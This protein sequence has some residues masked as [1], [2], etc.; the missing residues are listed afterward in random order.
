MNKKNIEKCFVI[1]SDTWPNAKCELI[2][3]NDFQLL[4]A[5]VL[6]A[7]TTDKSVNKALGPI[8]EKNQQFNAQDLLKIGE[9]QFLSLIKSIGLAPTKAKNAVKIASIL[10]EKFDS[11]VP[12][13]RVDLEALPGVGRKTTNVILNILN[14]EPIIAVDTHVERVSKRLNLASIQSNR[15]EVE[16]ELYSKIPEKF[17]DK[18]HHLLI[19][20]GRYL[21]TARN[22]KCGSC[23]LEKIC[24]K[25]GV[26]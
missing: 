20:Q 17:H 7:Q 15:V 25:I 13:N 14:N 6:S 16:H 11:K 24:P 4:I 12:L 23:P 9:I 10:L 5:V 19:F 1:L 21:C 18:T 22:P 26:T 8:F 2:Y 3:F